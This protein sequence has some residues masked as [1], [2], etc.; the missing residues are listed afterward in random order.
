ME[1]L[2]VDRAKK[3]AKWLAQ[4]A[5][6]ANTGTQRF[7][8]ELARYKFY[9][10]EQAAAGKVTRLGKHVAKFAPLL[11]ALPPSQRALATHASVEHAANFRVEVAQLPLKRDLAQL[12]QAE[13]KRRKRADEEVL[14]AGCPGEVAPEAHPAASEENRAGAPEDRAPGPSEDA[15]ELRVGHD[16]AGMEAP[17]QALRN[18]GV[19]L[20]SVFASD[21][22]KFACQTIEANFR[23]TTLYRGK[24]QGDI[25]KRDHSRAP[26]CDLYF[27]GW[28][29]QDNSTMGKRKGFRGARGQVFH[30]VLAYLRCHKPRLAVLENVRGLLSVNKGRDWRKVL[31]QLRGL[32]CYHLEWRVLNTAEHGVP[33]NRPRLY[34]VCIRNDLY[35]KGDFKWPEPIERPSVER[36]LDQCGVRPT[37]RNAQPP[38]QQVASETW[39]KKMAKL[40]RDGKPFQDPW[41]FAM[42]KRSTAM[43]DKCPCLLR[44]CRGIWVSNRGRLLNLR[45]RCRLQGMNPDKLKQVVSDAQ[46]QMQLGNS[47]SVNVVERLLSRPAVGLTGA[48]P[49]RWASGAAL[50]ELEATRDLVST[51]QQPSDASMLVE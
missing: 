27:A 42:F 34:I 5:E 10:E 7:Q 8:R 41:L 28:P 12:V 30:S 48:L 25:T 49:D 29:C 22:D 26:G 51:P 50:R 20:T 15:R 21:I 46:W 17:S 13:R 36:F 32:R 3:L 11:E 2:T 40:L 31:R 14:R 43:R 23:P 24:V 37:L 38:P 16:C 39:A 9:Q 44:S 35:R 47:M 19:S 18:L 4:E 6:K 1:K 33:Q 45:E